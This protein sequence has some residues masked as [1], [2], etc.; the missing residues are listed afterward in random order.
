LAIAASSA[1]AHSLGEPS[2]L[3]RREAIA[4]AV[5]A[6]AEDWTSGGIPARSVFTAAT[7]PVVSFAGGLPGEP[8]LPRGREGLRVGFG[9]APFSLGAAAFR[10]TGL[11][12]LGVLRSTAE[13]GARLVAARG[14]GA[15]LARFGFAG[16]FARGFAALAARARRGCPALAALWRRGC[17]AFA[18]MDRRRLAHRTS[19]PAS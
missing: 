19:R 14:A 18:V 10:V 1:F 8:A 7:A 4:N 13:T 17:A 2:P 12:P 6:S 15:A 3:S 11:P 5:A 16:A 9:F